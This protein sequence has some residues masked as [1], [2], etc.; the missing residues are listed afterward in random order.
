MKIAIQAA[1][2]DHPR[3]DGTRVYIWNLLKHFGNL[4]REDE[5]LIYHKGDFNPNL[6]PPEF[7]N[8]RAISKGFPFFWTQTRFAYEIWKGKPDVVW[9]PM[10][11]LPVLRRKGLKTVISVHDLAFKIFPEYF[12]EKDLRRLNFYADFAIRN[13]TKV[14]TDSESTKKDIA[15]FYPDIEQGKIK[16]IPLG[17]DAST[18]GRDFSKEGLEGARKKYGIPAG[19]YLLHVGAIQPRKN[20]ILLIKAFEILKKEKE[21]N[22]LKLVL[23]GEPAWQSEPTI[24][25]I[26]DSPFSR[27]IILVGKAGFSDLALIYGGASVFVL[28]SLYEGFGIPI[29]EALASG[30]PSVLARN[31]SIP[32]VAGDAALYFE[33]NSVDDLVSK[34]GVFLSNDALAAELARNGRERANDFSWEKC[35][36][37]TLEFLKG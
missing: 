31:S 4:G 27:D 12:P 16:V 32:D 19:R 28:P 8:Y 35:A 20:L 34:I 6:A 5:F 15:R 37:R 10:Q 21:N 1:D 18:F 30:V 9:L 3:I 24:Q 26:Q 33:N 13:A 22:D 11:A 7:G 36:E 2:L 14:I 29:L 23:A 25:A 17:F